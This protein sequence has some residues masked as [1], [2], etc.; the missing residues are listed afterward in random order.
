MNPAHV[1]HVCREVFADDTVL[2][3]D[4]G[5]I[6][7]WVHKLLLSN[8]YPQRL[9]TCGASGVIGYGVPGAMA[10]KLAWP[11]RRVLLLEAFT[12]ILGGFPVRL[13]NGPGESVWPRWR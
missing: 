11:R 7:Q 10:A 5:N 6:G 4:G 13:T 1:A 9:L 12:Y 8:R 2:V 3:V